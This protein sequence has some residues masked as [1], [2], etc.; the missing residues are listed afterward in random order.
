MLPNVAA[1]WANVLENNLTYRKLGTIIYR[2]SVL[3]N[4]YRIISGEAAYVLVSMLPIDIL[5]D[6]GSYL[7]DKT[8]AIGEF[9]A[10]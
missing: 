8:Y 10:E 4:A 7:Y 1:V 6:K 2:L 9:I 3:D 5:A